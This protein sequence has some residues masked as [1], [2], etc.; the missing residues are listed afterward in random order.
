MSTRALPSLL[1]A[2]AATLALACSS[3]GPHVPPAGE[4][5]R[6]ALFLYRNGLAL[7]L[8][9]RT[10]AA[11]ADVYSTPR[12]GSLKVV[13]DGV[14]RDL[15]DFL[16]DNG[17]ADHARSGPAPRAGAGPY[18]LAFEIESGG[19]TSHWG[20]NAASPGPE[21]KAMQVCYRHFLN[22]V[23]NVVQGFQTVDNPDG[24][25]LFDE[26]AASVRPR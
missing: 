23:F 21:Q 15:C 3:T 2:L 6:V 17:F 9:N 7:E 4:P 10:A 5:A 8:V 24:E 14:L 12:A 16:D 19:G 22:D 20:T 26:G 11:P 18:I 25:S 1:G 13:E